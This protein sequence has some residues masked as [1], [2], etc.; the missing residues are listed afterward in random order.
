MAYNESDQRRYWVPCPHCGHDQL[1]KWAQVRWPPDRPEEAGYVCIECGVVWSDVERWRAVQHGEWRADAP[2]NGTAGF[3]LNEL[4]SPWVATEG[5]RLG[6]PARQGPSRAAE[7]LDEYVTGRDFRRAGRRGRPACHPGARRRMERGWGLEECPG[8][9]LRR[10]R[11]GRS[12]RGRARRMGHRGGEL[13]GRPQDFLRRSVDAGTL[14]RTR[15]L[16]LDAE[17]DRGRSNASGYGDVHRHGRP[18]TQQ[19]YKFCKP[20]FNRRVYA[21]KGAGGIERRPVWPP[22]A[23]TKNKQRVNLYIIGVNAAKDVVLPVSSWRNLGAATVTF[24]RTETPNTSS[25]SRPR[26]W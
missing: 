9:Y 17:R 18:H 24:R 2:F 4:Y 16:S 10:G 11:A 22:R 1:L 23:S 5:N 19:A 25:S 7:G 26:R 15:R 13:V 20:R 12:P 21:I 14:E 8:H 3:H 6:F